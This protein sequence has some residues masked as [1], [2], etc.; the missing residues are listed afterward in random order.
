MRRPASGELDAF[1]TAATQARAF[2]V[3]LWTHWQNAAQLEIYGK[4]GAHTLVDNTGVLQFLGAANRRAAQEFVS[5]VGGLDP[6]EVMAMG[7]QEQFLLM[8]GKLQ[9]LRRLR[10]F[11]EERFRGQYDPV[12]VLGDAR[13]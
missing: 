8:D 7:A 4:D 6:D 1:L 5:L 10:H 3:Q 12:R 2:G 13:C 11:E 9:R